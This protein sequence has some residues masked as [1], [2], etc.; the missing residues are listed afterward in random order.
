MSETIKSVVKFTFEKSMAFCEVPAALIEQA[1][2]WTSHVL[3][4]RRADRRAEKRRSA[5]ALRRQ[6]LLIT[7]GSSAALAGAT[8]GERLRPKVCLRRL[9]RQGLEKSLS[10]SR[11]YVYA[12]EMSCTSFSLPLFC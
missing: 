1:K 10:M 7:A 9:C 2:A 4:E 3:P 11:C 6:H 5:A 8:I 12:R